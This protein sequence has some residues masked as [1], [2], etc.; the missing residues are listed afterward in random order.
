MVHSRHGINCAKPCIYWVL[1]ASDKAASRVIGA[2][3]F[4]PEDTAASTLPNVPVPPVPGAYTGENITVLEGLAAVRLRPAMY[5][6]A[7]LT[8]A[9]SRDTLTIPVGAVMPT[10]THNIVFVDKTEGRLEP[11]AV[12]LGEKYGDRYEVNAG[13]SEGERVVSSANFLIDAEA[14]VQGALKSFEEPAVTGS[15]PEA[16]R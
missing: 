1:R 10:G 14:K 3:S 4:V 2:F 8:A 12:S 7:V 11:R 9:G 15:N 13:L 5:V 6:S 16:K